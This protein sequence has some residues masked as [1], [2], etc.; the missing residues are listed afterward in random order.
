MTEPQG[1]TYLLHV[2][3]IT[4]H[5]RQHLLVD[6]PARTDGTPGTKGKICALT[7]P[8]CFPTMML[9]RSAKR[10]APKRQ[11]YIIQNEERQ[12]QNGI[13]DD[14]DIVTP[15]ATIQQAYQ[16]PLIACLSCSVHPQRCAGAA[17]SHELLIMGKLGLDRLLVES[18]APHTQSLSAPS[19]A[20][21]WE[22]CKLFSLAGVAVVVTICIGIHT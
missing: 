14:G 8:A 4:L 22:S 10:L 13:P 3:Q 20:S 19:Q 18:P 11:F 15:S 16:L 2:F 17:C 21:P 1:L 9:S 7:D 5:A 12:K 6:T